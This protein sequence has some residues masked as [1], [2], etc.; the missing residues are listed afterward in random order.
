MEVVCYEDAAPQ[1]LKGKLTI[2]E[3]NAGLN[4]TIRSKSQN[5][6]ALTIFKIIK[7]TK[8]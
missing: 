8:E 6:G 3:Q 7:L 5:S 2:E 4:R 1:M